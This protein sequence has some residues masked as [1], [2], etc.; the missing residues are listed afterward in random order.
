MTL[1][2]LAI[3]GASGL[4]GSRV[5]ELLDLDAADVLGRGNGF[6]LLGPREG[7]PER[8]RGFDWVLHFAAATNVDGCE[9]ERAQGAHGPA[10]R[11]NVE[12]SRA[13]AQA[14]KEAG[15]R[16]LYASTDFVFPTEAQGPHRED[17]QPARSASETNWYGWT[18]RCAEEEVRNVDR[19]NAILRISYPYRAAFE[20]KLDFARRIVDSYDRGQAFPLFEDQTLTPTF[21]DDVADACRII[22][23]GR[24]GVHHL[25]STDSTTPYE[26]GTRLLR[27]L[28][29][30]A[31][32][33][34]RGRFADAK[35]T[36]RAQRPQH[37]GL[38]MSRLVDEGF[39]PGTSEEGIARLVAQM[40][41]SS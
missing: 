1:P 13:L 18:K 27:S 36:G 19:R 26:F 12:G 14:A 33:V 17:A 9:R 4:V 30:D 38:A 39:E 2:R 31:G 5:R 32:R 10:W 16:V 25:G 11:L 37:G 22:I 8:L 40:R 24:G 28:G 3:T 6:D 23:G 34:A 15:A 21:V 41:A 7:W 29:R 35:R 20:R